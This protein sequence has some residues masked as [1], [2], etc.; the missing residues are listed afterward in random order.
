MAVLSS[1]QTA[2]SS[3]SAAAEN[4]TLARFVGGIAAHRKATAW[5][6]NA[7]ESSLARRLSDYREAR[8]GAVAS[9]L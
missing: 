9:W 7:A 2:S 8:I 5:A 3:R 1:W 4:Q 6:S